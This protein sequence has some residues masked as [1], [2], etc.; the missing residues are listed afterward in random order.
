[1]AFDIIFYKVY[2]TRYT[3]LNIK[4]KKYKKESVICWNSLLAVTNVTFE[5]SLLKHELHLVDALFYS[6]FFFHY[7]PATKNKWSGNVSC[8]ECVSK[9]IQIVLIFLFTTHYTFR[10]LRLI[11][12]EEVLETWCRHYVDYFF[13][14]SSILF[15]NKSIELLLDVYFLLKAHEILCCII[16][17]FV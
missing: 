11:N 15:I 17:M 14:F 4:Y 6:Y 1:M 12:C 2:H 10:I 7:V 5:P 3:C 8:F 13:A 16:Y 9:W